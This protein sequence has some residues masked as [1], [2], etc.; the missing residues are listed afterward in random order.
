MMSSWREDDLEEQREL[1]AELVDFTRSATWQRVMR[2]AF[3]H[4][5]AEISRKLCVGQATSLEEIREMQT[6]YRFISQI[7]ENP[8]QF[9]SMRKVD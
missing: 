7:L 6:L 2:P 4:R 5:Q 9:F 8:I 1:E 3:L